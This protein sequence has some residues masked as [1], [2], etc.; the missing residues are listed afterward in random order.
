MAEQ[1]CMPDPTVPKQILQ[2]QKRM[3]VSPRY[4][5]KRTSDSCTA[6]VPTYAAVHPR[7]DFLNGY[8]AGSRPY[9]SLLLQLFRFIS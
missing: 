3:I 7:A 2:N 4:R 9:S 5:I 6:K 8:D 1:R